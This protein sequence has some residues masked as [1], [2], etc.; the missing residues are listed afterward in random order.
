MNLSIFSHS[1][2]RV[3]L[4]LFLHDYF[5]G[6]KRRGEQ[7]DVPPKPPSG[8]G[9][10]APVAERA[11]PSGLSAPSGLATAAESH[12]A[13]ARTPPRVA[14]FS[15][16]QRWCINIWP[17]W[18]NLRQLWRAV[19]VLDWPMGLA[20]ACIIAQLP[21]LPT[22]PS[23]PFYMYFSQRHSPTDILHT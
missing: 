2:C 7:R 3:I 4:F 22:L 21:L 9:L 19:L 1:F 17:S 20:R 23:H 14:V 18:P 11:P 6:R 15:D 16:L 12:P 10:L 13:Q 8:E 5:K